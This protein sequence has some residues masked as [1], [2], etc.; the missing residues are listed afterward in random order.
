M[1]GQVAQY[2]LPAGLSLIELILGR[3]TQKS[4]AENLLLSQQREADRNAAML[5]YLQQEEDR[6]FMEDKRRY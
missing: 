3:K 4:Y 6:R 5:R 2:G 1:W